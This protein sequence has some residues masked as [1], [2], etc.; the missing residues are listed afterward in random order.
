MY[1]IALLLNSHYAIASGTAP[2]AIAPSTSMQ[3]DTSARP[4]LSDV[5]DRFRLLLQAI[6]PVLNFQ[7][8]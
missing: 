7:Y 5:C 3:S 8:A 6:A 4:L 1:A 2:W